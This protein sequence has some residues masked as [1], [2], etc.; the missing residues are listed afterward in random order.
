MQLPELVRRQLPQC[1][2][3]PDRVV[4][5]P[6]CLNA[7]ARIIHADERMLIQTFLAHS[8]IEALDVRVLYRL[9]GADDLQAHAM[10]VCPSVQRPA[11][12]FWPVIDLNQRRATPL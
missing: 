10:P 2:V 3:R 11:H 6:P 4:V 9:A 7:P 5:D 8:P 1:A 12:E